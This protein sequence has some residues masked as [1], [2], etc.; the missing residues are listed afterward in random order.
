[1]ARCLL[2]SAAPLAALLCLVSTFPAAPARRT[3]ALAGPRGRRSAHAPT[4]HE[5]VLG[6]RSHAARRPRLRNPA[7]PA[8]PSPPPPDAALRVRAMAVRDDDHRPTLL[9]HPI[10]GG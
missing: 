2:W 7:P 4:P 10:Y 1:M 3:A 8:G 9:P 6:G 5:P